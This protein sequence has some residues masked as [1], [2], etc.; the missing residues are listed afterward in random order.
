MLIL[1]WLTGQVMSIR[2]NPIKLLLAFWAFATY[3]LY[4]IGM[5][6]ELYDTTTL[7]AVIIAL[8][9]MVAY[10]ANILTR[11]PFVLSDKYCWM[12]LKRKCNSAC[13]CRCGSE[14]EYVETTWK[15]KKQ[16]YTIRTSGTGCMLTGLCS[17]SC[18]GGRFLRLRIFRSLRAPF[19]TIRF[20]KPVRVGTAINPSNF[21]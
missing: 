7:M 3:V 19:S 18:G 2:R 9:L 20:G 16:C 4:A 8:G 15:G 21:P 14:C 6:W 13:N 1:R 11:E 10:L 5:A 12:C 17:R